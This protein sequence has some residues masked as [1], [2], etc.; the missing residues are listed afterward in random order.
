MPMLIELPGVCRIEQRDGHIL[1]T[2]DDG[3]SSANWPHPDDPSYVDVARQCGFTDL[4]AYCAA[5]GDLE[6]TAAMIRRFS[7]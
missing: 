2:F 1:T 5:L 4:M 7:K 3:G 6:S